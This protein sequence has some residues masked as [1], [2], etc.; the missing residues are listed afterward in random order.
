MALIIKPRKL[1]PFFIIAVVLVL[2]L[3][4]LLINPQA[5]LIQTQHTFE[6]CPFLNNATFYSRNSSYDINTISPAVDARALEIYNYALTESPGLDASSMHRLACFTATL[7]DNRYLP[8]YTQI[9]SLSPSYFPHLSFFE[10]SDNVRILNENYRSCPRNYKIVYFLMAHK[11]D[12]LLNIQK[13]YHLLHTEDTFFYFHID[14]KV[15]LVFQQLKDWL[16]TDEMKRCGHAVMPVQYNILWGHGSM[17]TAQL[18]AYFSIHHLLTFEYIINLSTDH[19]PLKST[20]AQYKYLSR[21]EG[22]SYISVLTETHM[23]RLIHPLVET[24]HG[25]KIVLQATRH[26]PFDL[27]PVKN[28]QWSVIHSSFINQLLTSD[29]RLM[30][31]AEHT[32]IPDEMFFATFAKMNDI[33]IVDCVTTFVHFSFGAKHPDVVSVEQV[34]EASELEESLFIRKVDFANVQ[35][36]EAA[37]EARRRADEELGISR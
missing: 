17:V 22:N 3:S 16:A 2:L 6:Y 10:T 25:V 13:L 11:E 24:K 31:F 19:Y 1:A 8:S 30:A 9:T 18:E 5:Q 29:L 34:R 20:A 23:D 27:S 32:L 12:S 33:E 26:W 28:S 14:K 4:L 36:M 21:L 37:D 7:G 15:P 35:V